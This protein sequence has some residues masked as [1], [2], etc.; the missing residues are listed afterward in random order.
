MKLNY[1][2]LTVILG[3]PEMEARRMIYCA[4]HPELEEMPEREELEAIKYGVSSADQVALENFKVLSTSWIDDLH[5]QNFVQW[6]VKMLQEHGVSDSL[7]RSITTDH[8]NVKAKD[9]VGKY[10][11]LKSILPTKQ[12]RLISGILALKSGKVST[13]VQNFAIQAEN[14]S[15][16]VSKLQTLNFEPND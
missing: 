15:K 8:Q 5:G 12:L 3:V 16:Q 14:A 7:M 6:T 11:V 9:L 1:K 10:K 13:R 2:D 4:L